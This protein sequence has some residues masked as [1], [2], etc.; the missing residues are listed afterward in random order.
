[1]KNEPLLR[2]RTTGQNIFFF[3]ARFFS[4]GPACDSACFHRGSL[5]SR[6]QSTMK[7]NNPV[8]YATVSDVMGCVHILRIHCWMHHYFCLNPLCAEELRLASQSME[9]KYL[10]G[11]TW[12]RSCW[13]V[14]PKWDSRGFVKRLPRVGTPNCYKILPLRGWICIVAAT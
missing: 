9:C 4:K 3:N 6:L 13:A 14:P 7:G 1:M 5:E 12:L 10:V 11:D 8:F 2:N